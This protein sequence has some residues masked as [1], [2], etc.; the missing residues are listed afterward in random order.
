MIKYLKNVSLLIL[1]IH[2]TK[3]TDDRQFLELKTNNNSICDLKLSTDNMIIFDKCMLSLEWKLFYEKETSQNS[4]E[5]YEI[6][7]A[8][9]RV[10]N[11]EYVIDNQKSQPDIQ[12]DNITIKA[13]NKNNKFLNDID[14]SKSN[15]FPLFLKKGD[16]FDVIIEYNQ[17]NYNFT[18]IKLV[19]T[20]FLRNSKS[21]NLIDI[22]FGY[23]KIILDE[24]NKKMNL[25]Y[26]FLVLC[27]II[28]I[29]LIKLKFLVEENQFIRIHI[30]EIMQGKNAEAILVV[31][32]TVL[33]VL[34]FFMIIKYIY[35]ITFIFS[36]LLA[37]LSVKS[38]FK[39]LFKVISPSISNIL[40][41]NN[42]YI[43]K[44]SIDYSNVLFYPLSVLVLFWWYNITDEYFNLHTLLNNI[45][46][47]IIV[48]FNV[49]KL[50]I[51]N[52]YIITGICFIIV[53]YQI[54]KAV[55]DE[56]S[57][58]NDKDNIYYITTK[59]IIDVPIRFILIDF[60]DSPFEEIYFFSILDL[61]LIGF[62]IHYC[63]SAYNLSSAY[64]MISIYST[65]TGLIINLI[66]FYGYKFAPPF[67]TIPIILNLFG[68]IGYSVYQKQFLDFMD[69]ENAIAQ[70][71]NDIQVLEEIEEEQTNQFEFLK[72]NDI[73]NQN[74]NFEDE[75]N[76]L[77][78]KEEDKEGDE[79]DSDEE[80]KRKHENLIN[81]FNQRLS[82][83]KISANYNFKPSINLERADDSNENLA[84]LIDLVDGI[85]EPRKK[86][87]SFKSE[88]RKRNESTN[89]YSK[90]SSDVKVIE[91]KEL[92]NKKDKE[93]EKEKEKEDIKE[94]VNEKEN[95]KENEK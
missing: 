12:I 8:V 76:D 48:Y 16:N 62:I 54:I 27:F 33:T 56:D 39:Y 1:L 31:V 75:Y 92:M 70:E 50:N 87:N 17:Y 67:S 80:D 43:Q 61:T 77:R 44:F 38:F 30:D 78:I 93:K 90:F 37:I 14:I 25:T 49:H 41:N 42:L 29:F 11:F 74:Q 81:N 45:I 34:L 7:E 26:F 83:R 32:G 2:I 84:K 94:E 89:I 64:F 55:V 36:I 23:K 15:K 85:K 4:I 57:V 24:F 53:I 91:M 79:M 9:R 20:V 28:L 19:V 46:F 59:F 58:Q 47:I 21:T 86:N 69:V 73:N 63:D 35:Y 6:K 52:F 22:N 10:F 60:V 66:L 71:L 3:Q 18:Y 40:N 13:Y 95:W 88:R 68:L 51:K 5:V 82:S 65:L 72:N